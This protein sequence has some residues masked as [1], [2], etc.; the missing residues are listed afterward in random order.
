MWVVLNVM[1]STLNSLYCFV[2]GSTRRPQTLETTR[3]KESTTKVEKLS[4]QPTTA[5]PSTL[6]NQPTFNL[7]TQGT[8]SLYQFRLRLYYKRV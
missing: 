4:T 6:Q 2:S 7:P 5:R 8:M 1:I 3:F